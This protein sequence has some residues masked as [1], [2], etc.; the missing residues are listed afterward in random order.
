MEN[1]NKE[2]GMSNQ[3][4]DPMKSLN[5]IRDS[6][7]RFIEDGISMATGAQLVPVDVYETETSVIVKAGPILGAQPEN[8]DVALVGDTLTIKGETRPDEEVETESYLRR[9]RKFGAFTR[10]VT[11][12]R[13]VKADQ[14]VASFKNG[15][16]TITLPKTEEPQPKVINVKP[17]DS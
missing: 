2:P 16:L 11:I 10:A 8:I 17:V 14:A 13:P 1:D 7:S 4:F 9:E 6:V 5:Q 3:G 12:P 15:M